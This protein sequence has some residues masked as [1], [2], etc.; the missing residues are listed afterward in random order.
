MVIMLM[1]LP[2]VY[3]QILMMEFLPSWALAM[4]APLALISKQQ[5]G[6]E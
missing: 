1:H 3:S 5:M 2:V 4:R 6:A